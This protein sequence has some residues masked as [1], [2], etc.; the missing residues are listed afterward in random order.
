MHVQ[1]AVRKSV[2][3]RSYF[4]RNISYEIWIFQTRGPPT[5]GCELLLAHDLLGPGSHNGR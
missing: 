1:I 5:Q 2:L 4:L 3:L